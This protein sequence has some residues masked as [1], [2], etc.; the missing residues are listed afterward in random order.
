MSIK[1]TVLLLFSLSIIG[2]PVTVSLPRPTLLANSFF[3]GLIK[4]SHEDSHGEFSKDYS[5]VP[6]KNAKDVA[7]QKISE[8]MYDIEVLAEEKK[9]LQQTVRDIE[10]KINDLQQKA[11]CIKDL[12]A[13]NL[14][15]KD[16]LCV[17][18]PDFCRGSKD[19][20]DGIHL[21]AVS[22][23]S[24]DSSTYLEMS[25]NLPFNS[26]GEKITLSEL[27]H[28]GYEI[29]PGSIKRNNTTAEHSLL[30]YI[31]NLFF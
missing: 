3:K 16:C 30:T 31:Y 28:S 4:Y 11:S 14:M 10:N 9:L 19:K 5:P 2:L 8:Y 17:T 23:G 21:T 20:R 25:G 15:E 29:V 27:I 24:P 7:E 18:M 6:E 13:L 12:C 26:D 1:N 22:L